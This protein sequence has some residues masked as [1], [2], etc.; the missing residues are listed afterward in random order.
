MVGARSSLLIWVR[1]MITLLLSPL[2]TTC[3]LYR[4]L[5]V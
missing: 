5:R 4:A 1:N 3:Y 2:I